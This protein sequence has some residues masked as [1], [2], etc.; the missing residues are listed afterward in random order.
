MRKL[1]SCMGVMTLLGA[2]LTGC[3]M[4]PEQMK[5]VPIEDQ[6]KVEALHDITKEAIKTYFDV[7]VNDGVERKLEGFESYVLVDVPTESYLYRNNVIKATVEG[8]PEEG[9]IAS[10]GASLNPETNALTGAIVV[11]YSEGKAQDLTIEQQQEI[12]MNFIKEK[13]L[14]PNPDSLIFEGIEKGMSN[15]Y[16]S[17]LKFKNGEDALIVSISLQTGKVTHFEFVKAIKP[18]EQTEVPAE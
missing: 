17:G 11:T 1:L 7:D 13:N 4:G 10:Y 12:A 5:S 18:V 9:Q 14:V 8:K 6:A 2:F 3:S 16:Y 15:K